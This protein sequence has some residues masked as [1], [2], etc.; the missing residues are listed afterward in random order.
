MAQNCR[1]CQGCAR[2]AHRMRKENKSLAEIREAVDK[3]YP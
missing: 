3:R 1:V 2:I